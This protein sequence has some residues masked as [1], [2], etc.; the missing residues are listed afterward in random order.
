M[1]ADSG[2]EF[3]VR[4]RI[5]GALAATIGLSFAG[6]AVLYAAPEQRAEKLAQMRRRYRAK[7]GARLRAG[8][9]GERR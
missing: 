1:T 4:R 7:Y 5:A 8:E 6:G 9:A 3:T 2:R